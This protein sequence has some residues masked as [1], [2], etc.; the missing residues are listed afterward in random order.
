VI[1]HVTAEGLPVVAL[2]TSTST[3]HRAN[4]LLPDTRAELALALR[5]N[6]GVI[7]ALDVQSKQVEAFSEADI[8]LFQGIADQLAVAITNVRLFEELQTRVSEIEA[9]NRRLVGEAWR[10]YATSRRGALPAASTDDGAADSWSEWQRQA[11]ETGQ[12]VE[13]IGEK[14]VTLAVPVSLRGEVL[15]AI[16]WDIPRE[17]YTEEARQLAQELAARLAISADNAR[18]F[19]Q[20]QRVAEREALV[21]AITNKLTQQTNVARILWVAA[22]E[23]GQALRVPQTS[24]RLS[25][26]QGEDVD[27]QSR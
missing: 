8:N 1:G 2:D 21:N 22:R 13:H 27:T 7:G 14:T 24:I 19:D 11:V 12:I 16:E 25:V 6:E 5:T 15:G 4:E 10:G 3:I 17:S 9:L 20:A 26:G 23:V 18:L